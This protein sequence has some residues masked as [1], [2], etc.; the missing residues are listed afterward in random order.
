MLS[1]TPKKKIE[2]KNRHKNNVITEAAANAPRQRHGGIGRLESAVDRQRT[3][4][5]D[6]AA[7]QGS[8]C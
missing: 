1:F 4:G 2:K 8:R 5:G 6:V 7:R 3:D